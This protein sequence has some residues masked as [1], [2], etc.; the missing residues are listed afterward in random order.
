MVLDGIGST[1]GILLHDN[2]NAPRNLRLGGKVLAR[3]KLHELEEVALAHLLETL[4]DRLLATAPCREDFYGMTEVPTD[5]RAAKF[6]VV[7]GL[8]LD[9]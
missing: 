7:S 5:Y 1:V 8:S 4:V 6:R 2:K 9:R 3:E